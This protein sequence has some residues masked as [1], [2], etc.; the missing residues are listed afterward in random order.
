MTGAALQTGPKPA[1]RAARLA[2]WVLTVPGGSALMM[3]TLISFDSDLWPIIYPEV[4]LLLVW[5]ACVVVAVCAAALRRRWW[6]AAMLSAAIVAAAPVAIIALRG[7]TYIHLITMLPI[8]ARQTSATE[9]TIF[10]W[11]C[12]GF[13]GAAASCDTLVHDPNDLILNGKITP[14][15]RGDPERASVRHLLGHYYLVSATA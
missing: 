12:T 13:V 6:N 9:Q 15:I 10:D 1:F 5:V 2:A 7:G 14:G 4:L 11:G 8:Y 3:N